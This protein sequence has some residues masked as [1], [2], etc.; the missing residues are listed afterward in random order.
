MF[1]GDQHNEATAMSER[2]P[3]AIREA[4]RADA[5]W[6]GH[7]LRAHWSATTVVVHGEII[8]AAALPA[9]IAANHQGLATYRRHGQDAELVT[10]NAV[11]P[12]IGTGSALIEALSARLS[13]EGRARLWL[14]MS[15]ANLSALRF[16][17]R[18]GFRL[19]R[20]R[21]GAVDAARSL[22]PSIPQV[23]EHGIPMHDELDLCRV[24]DPSAAVG[25]FPPPRWNHP[26]QQTAGNTP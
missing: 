15:N 25:V 20:V 3:A 2:L 23:G 4:G 7:F 10:L 1:D 16:Y 18:R 19:M 9:L 21:I 22:K 12:G 26:P 5:E 24:L 13:A 6:I 8:N 11:P 17:Q 14:T